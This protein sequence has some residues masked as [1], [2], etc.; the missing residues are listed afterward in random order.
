M[1]EISTKISGSPGREHSHHRSFWYCGR[2]LRC[3]VSISW[4][5]DRRSPRT[6]P[7]LS[8]LDRTRFSRLPRL[9]IQS[10]MAVAV[11][12][13]CPGNGLAEYGFARGVCSYRRFSDSRAAR[14]GLHSAVDS[15]THTNCHSASYWRSLDSCAW[16]HK[17]RSHRLADNTGFGCCYCPARTKAQHHPRQA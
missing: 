9:L 10:I 15:E 16:H 3:D 12:S 5:L 7:S 2:L 11:S 1:E 8:H 14:H 6:P 17:R 13:S 4:R